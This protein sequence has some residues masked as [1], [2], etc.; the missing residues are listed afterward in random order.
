MPTLTE[1]DEALAHAQA[2]AV[3]ERGAAW[4]AYVDKLLELR[5]DLQPDLVEAR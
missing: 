1:V 4:H 5:R 2:V 3:D